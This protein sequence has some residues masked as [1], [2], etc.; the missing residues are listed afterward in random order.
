MVERPLMND[1]PEVALSTIEEIFG[2]SFVRHTDGEADA[3][4]PFASVFPE[5]AAQVESLT[6][7][8]ARYRIPLVARGAGTALYPG[9]ASRALAVRFDAMREIRLP[10]EPGEDWV[11]VE[12]GVT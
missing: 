9:R 10:K 11:E 1:I 4:Q 7:L 2:T 12:P 5:N 8:A 3:G 6:K